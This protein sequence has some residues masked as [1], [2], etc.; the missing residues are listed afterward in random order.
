MVRESAQKTYKSRRT[1]GVGRETDRRVPVIWQSSEHQQASSR[2]GN[3]ALFVP[4]HADSQ[5]RQNTMPSK[6]I[7]WPTAQD[8][9]RLPRPAAPVPMSC[10]WWY[11]SLP[12]THLS[13]HCGMSLLTTF[14]DVV[15]PLQFGFHG[16]S[17]TYSQSWFM[18]TL[19][20]SEPFYR[21]CLSLAVSFE[22]GKRSGNQ[23]GDPD[24]HLD[25]RRLQV[26]A[27][28]G[29]QQQVNQLSSETDSGI[30][31][32]RKGTKALSIMNQ[33][34]SLEVFSFI[35]GQ[36]VSLNHTADHYQIT[37]ETLIIVPIT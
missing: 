31:I 26:G 20:T 33:L 35:E 9:N 8:C 12:N 32:L 18:Q 14:L 3:A 37:G 10:A 6:A 24:L 30:D 34:L 15:F 13:L 16:L 29:L 17:E 5:L 19:V 28:Q 7:T 21:A 36:W 27:I 4:Y 25:A 1:R 2:V 11:E 23:N 22:W